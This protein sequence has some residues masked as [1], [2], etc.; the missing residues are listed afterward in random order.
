MVGKNNEMHA[1]NELGRALE[2]AMVKYTDSECL[3][4][5]KR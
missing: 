3:D 4:K 5:D 2:A 1:L